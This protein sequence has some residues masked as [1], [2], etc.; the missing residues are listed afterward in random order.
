MNINEF[1]HPGMVEENQFSVDDSHSASQIGSGDLRV[2][3]TPAMISFM[4]KTSH[5]LLINHL[6]PGQTSVGTKV[7]VRH[8]APTPMGSTVKVRSEVLQVEGLRVKFLIQAWDDQEQIGEGLHERAV[9][10]EKRFLKRV[11][12]KLANLKQN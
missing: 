8:L 4:E 3:A 2:L 6:P 9:I 12:S 11:A 1:I 5:R 7:E 10:D